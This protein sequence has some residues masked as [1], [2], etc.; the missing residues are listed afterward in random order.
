MR[1]EVLVFLPGGG[2]T[3]PGLLCQSIVGRVAVGMKKPR[4]R[5]KNEALVNKPRQGRM[6]Q[7][8]TPPTTNC[9][10]AHPKLEGEAKSSSGTQG[11]KGW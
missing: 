7:F 8:D 5:R 6:V 9:K 4:G 3:L 2:V 11:D 1:T 10:H